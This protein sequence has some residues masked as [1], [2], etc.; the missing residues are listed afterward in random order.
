MFRVKSNPVFSSVLLFVC[1]AVSSCSS[2]YK[3]EGTSSITGLDGK[4]LFLKTLKGD[5]WVDVDSA[6]VVHGLF[7]MDGPV[8]SAMMVTLYMDDDAIMPLVLEKG[9]IEVTI[10]DSQ[11][12][13]KGTSLNDALYEFIGKRN[14]MEMRLGELDRK[15]A[16]MVL[17]GAGIDEAHRQVAAEKEALI[18]EVNDYVKKFISDNYETVLGPSVFSMMCSSLPYPVMTPVIED[19]V[20]GAPSSFLENA[21]VKD[22]L[23]KARENMRLM[24]EHQRL[25]ENMILNQNLQK[26]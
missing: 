17:D 1:L 26:R 25:Q 9:K 19:L 14:G 21:Y 4:K 18:K 24:E 6:D 5:T 22:Y 15:E 2:R 23:S 3:V 11:L 8:D 13:V 7:K 16:R 20:K 12:E 10:S